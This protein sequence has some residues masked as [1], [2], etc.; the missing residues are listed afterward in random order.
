MIQYAPALSVPS[1]K[2]GSCCHWYASILFTR[3]PLGQGRPTA[4][5]CVEEKLRLIVKGEW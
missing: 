4:S 3:T 1:R 2:V 5:L